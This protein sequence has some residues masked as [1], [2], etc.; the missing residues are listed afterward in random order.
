MYNVDV[1]RDLRLDGDQDGDRFWIGGYRD[2]CESCSG[3]NAVTVGRRFTALGDSGS[4]DFYLSNLEVGDRAL[5]EG[6]T[7]RDD[8][9]IHHS[10][11]YANLDI[12][13]NGGGDDALLHDVWVGGRVKIEMGGQKD[14]LGLE[15]VTVVG[16]QILTGGGDIDR[17]FEGDGNSVGGAINQA[18]QF[19]HFLGPA[20]RDEFFEDCDFDDPIE[21]L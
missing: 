7:G 14:C 18:T 1:G 8:L 17:L 6:W 21:I 13:M 5:I 4:D 16:N 12:R 3:Y 2:T 9:I 20:D 10:T 11:F 15:Y 19:E